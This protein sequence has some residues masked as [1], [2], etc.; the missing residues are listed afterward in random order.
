MSFDNFLQFLCVREKYLP[1]PLTDYYF[2]FVG[3]VILQT[4]FIPFSQTIKLTVAG[5]V[6][7][8]FFTLQITT[9]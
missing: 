2:F 5:T 4:Y 9:N 6:V 1:V 3:K 8:L 7:D